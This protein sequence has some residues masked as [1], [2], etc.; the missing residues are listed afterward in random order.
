MNTQHELLK[1]FL[2]AIAYRTQKALRDAP[3]A[4]PDFHAANH[5]RQPHELVWH[6]PAV[7]GYAITYFRGGVWQ[8][9][10]LESFAAEV[11]RFHQTLEQ[12]AE[13][14]ETQSPI[15]EISPRQLL[16]GPLAD[17]M[18]HAGQ[19]AML[20]RLAGHPVPPEN[21]IRAR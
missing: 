8:P 10:K 20:R 7:L 21:F 3:E 2:A 18:T 15:R 14:L 4:F 6:M 1:H 13:M 11:A 5:V 9:E 16:Q 19:L 17:V 12:L